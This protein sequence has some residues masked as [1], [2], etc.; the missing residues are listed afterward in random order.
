MSKEKTHIELNNEVISPEGQ[1]QPEKDKEAVNK[2]FVN[3][4]NMNMVWFHDLEEKINYLLDNNYYSYE[5]FSKYDMEDVKKVFKQAYS[6][7]FRF[8]S[9]MSAEKFYSQ[10]ALKTHD[11]KH[12]LERYEDRMSVVA[13]F[14]ADGDISEAFK[15]IDL[16]MTQQY[17]PATP[18]V[19]NAGLFN[20]G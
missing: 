20:A 15:F 8:P 6:Y 11:G 12:Y 9:Y 4:V 1:L 7:K 18:T 17:Q 14:F 13:L 2:Y 19:L 5:L 10:Y 16:L 3:E